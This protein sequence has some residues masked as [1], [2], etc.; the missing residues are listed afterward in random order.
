MKAMV[1]AAGVGSRLDP[2]TRA[3]PKPVVPVANRPVIEHIIRLLRRHGFD[4]LVVNLHYLGHEIERRLGDGSALGVRIRYEWEDQL[5]GDA[6]SAKRVGDFFDDTFLVVGGDDLCDTDLTT[7][8]RFHRERGALATISLYEVQ[9][10]SEY[11]IV[12]TDADGRVMRF[13][14]KPR[15]GEVFSRMANTGLY[16]FEPAALRTIP[17][18]AFYG[19]GR[20]LFPRLLEAGQPIYATACSRYW[21]DVGNLEEYRQSQWD[22]LAGDAGLEVPGKELRPGLRIDAGCEIHP[23]A[24]L[25]KNVLVGSS[26]RIGARARIGDYAIL[27]SGCVVGEGAKVDHTILWDDVEV[28]PGTSLHGAIA[29]HGARLA[30]NLT[31]FHAIA[32]PGTRPGTE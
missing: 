31:L 22:A 6:G 8:I 15:G 4:D 3:V 25:G 14:E 7:L 12:E 1:L 16:L 9:D 29:T 27:G 23:E 19:F 28:A 30:A 21:R 2:L 20:D 26:C 5:W 24:T 10:P 17:P 18:G 11:G 13:L 32:A